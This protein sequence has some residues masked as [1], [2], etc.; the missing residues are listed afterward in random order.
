[1]PHEH[2]SFIKDNESG[3]HLPE[4]CVAPTVFS[5]KEFILVAFNVLGYCEICMFWVWW[6]ILFLQLSDLCIPHFLTASIFS[7]QSGEAILFYRNTK[8]LLLLCLSSG[9]FRFTS[10]WRTLC[11]QW[12]SH[13]DYLLGHLLDCPL[14]C[15]F[16]I[17]FTCVVDSFLI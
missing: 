17:L 1:M 6:L 4:L 8:I 16:V 7:A 2:Q 10:Y 13:F 5:T 12:V 11:H 15:I 14:E 3:E 9:I